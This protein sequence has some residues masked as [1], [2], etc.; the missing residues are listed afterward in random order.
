MTLSSEPVSY[1]IRATK[2]TEA[3]RR[4]RNVPLSVRVVK[5]SIDLSFAAAGLSVSAWLV[6]LLGLAIYLESPGP[7]L[8]RQRRVAAVRRRDPHGRCQFREFDMLKL[9]T[10]RVDAEGSTGAVLATENDPR[11]TRIG[12]LL[13]KTRLDELP[14]LYNVLVGDMSLVGPRPERPELLENLALAIP[15]FEERMH[16]CRPGITGFAQVSL[17]YSGHAPRHS[18]VARFEATLTDPLHLHLR[19]GSIADDMRMKLL[20]DLAYVT[21]LESF[22]SYITLELLV[23]AKT[24]WV[25]LRGLGR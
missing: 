4:P 13:R 1:S 5:R 17:G 19:E 16:D 11:V 9:R 18:R 6:P 24:P 10:M 12:R 25:M 23:L 2:P 21:A 7:I 22:R 8:Y 3:R 20:F 15:Y 14:Q